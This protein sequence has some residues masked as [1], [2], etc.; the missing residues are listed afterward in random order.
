M[1]DVHTEHCCVLH[2][3]K[4]GKDDIC[5]VTQKIAPQSFICETCNDYGIT[6]LEMV[7]QIA[8]TDKVKCCPHCGHII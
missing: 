6:T 5:T 8:N 4:Y 3:C 1:K 2:G 7:H